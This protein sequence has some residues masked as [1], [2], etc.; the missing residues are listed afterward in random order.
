MAYRANL[1]SH[2]QMVTTEKFCKGF[3]GTTWS[4]E[5]PCR[6]WSCRFFK[7]SRCFEIQTGRDADRCN[8]YEKRGSSFKIGE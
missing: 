6:R 7:K 1:Y 2:G 4:K 5:N 3:D 8:W